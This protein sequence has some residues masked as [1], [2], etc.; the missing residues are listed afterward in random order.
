ML[1]AKSERCAQRRHPWSQTSAMRPSL[2]DRCLARASSWSVA[3]TPRGTREGR[4]DSS[5]VRL[6]LLAQRAADE[7]SR[8]SASGTGPPDPS[9]ICSGSPAASRFAC[10]GAGSELR[11]G[12]D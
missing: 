6:V 7:A 2:G 4:V 10:R 9:S 12:L 8:P 1:G 5:G 3:V 11:L